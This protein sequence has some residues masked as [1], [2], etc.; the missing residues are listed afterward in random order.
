MIAF[1]LL[2]LANITAYFRRV[3]NSQIIK[4]VDTYVE[5][6]AQE[7]LLL[8]GHRVGDNGTFFIRHFLTSSSFLITH[9]KNKMQRFYTFDKC[10]Y[11][12]SSQSKATL[13]NSQ[14]TIKILFALG[15]KKEEERC[16]VNHQGD[17]HACSA[18]KLF[19]FSYA[20]HLHP[21]C[22][23]FITCLTYIS[24]KV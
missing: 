14:L 11:R 4:L 19:D 24:R 23:A 18:L 10:Y 9:S 22:S 3:Q 1:A 21:L 15:R 8:I 12:S 7:P 5:F 17:K 13:S 6:F 16:G 2:R 20:L